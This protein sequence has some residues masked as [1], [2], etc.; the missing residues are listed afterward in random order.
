M[1]ADLKNRIPAKGGQKRRFLIG[2]AARRAEGSG[3]SQDEVTQAIR[4]FK[5][6]GGLINELPP[7]PEDV[8]LKVGN[9]FTAA[10]ESV[11]EY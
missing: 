2:K 6:Q 5:A 7:E 9:H 4:R 1:K 10:F 3:V 11:I 8:R